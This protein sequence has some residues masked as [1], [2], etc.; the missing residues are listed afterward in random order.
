MMNRKRP[1]GNG[2]VRRGA[3]AL[4]LLAALILSGA[5]CA[6]ESGD[7]PQV[8]NASGNRNGPLAVD[9]IENDEGFSAILYDNRNGLPTSEA[10]AIAQTGD[11]F[12][13]IGSYAGLIRYDGNTFERIQ[14]EEGILN[15]RCLY[16]DSRDRLWI[17]TNDF[18]VFCMSKGMLKRVDREDQ[19]VSVSI[20]AIAEDPEGVIYVGSAAGVATVDSELNLSL[21]RDDRLL[22]ET[23]LDMRAGSDGLIYGATQSGDLFVMKDGKVV[24]FMLPGESRAGNIFAVLPDPLRPGTVY[25]AAENEQTHTARIYCGT[26]EDGF[27]SARVWDVSPLSQVERIESIDGEIWI[28][29]GNGIGKLDENG[30][31]QLHGIPMDK[32]VGHVMTDSDGNLWFTSTRQCVMKIVPNRFLDL[33]QHYGLSEEIVNATC[34]QGQRLF[35]GTDSG[36]IV[37]ENGKKLESVPLDRAVT[38]SG[39][40]LETDDL[41]AYLKGV[42]IRSIIRDSGD[43]LWIGTWSE[44]GLLCYDGSGLTAFT[45]ED[46]MISAQARMVCEMEDGTIVAGQPDG[47]SVIR[48]GRVTDRFGAADGLAVT[49]ILTV[50]EGFDHE[51]ILGSDGGGIYIIDPD[52]PGR[53]VKHI[54]VKDGLQ[55]EVILRIKRSRCRDVLWIATGN[56]LAFMTPDMQVTTVRHFPYS[57]NYDMYE[58]STGD[59]WVLSSNGIYVVSADEML[60]NGEIGSF[61]Y[62]IPSGL[63]YIATSNSYSELTDAGELYI[64]GVKGTIKVNI[65][66]TSAQTGGMRPALPFIDIDGR[67]IYP[68]ENG[69]FTVPHGVRKLTVYPYVF[70]YFL[71]DPEVSYRLE[72]FDTADTTVSRS[73][74]GPV[75]YTNLR[76]GEY[77]FV[78]RVDDPVGKDGIAVSFGIVKEKQITENAAATIILDVASIFFM[79]GILIYTSLY[80]KRGRVDDKLFFGMVLVNM[81]IAFTELTSFLMENNSGPLIREL[82]YTQNTVFY[83]CL[84]FFTYLF[85]L[86]LDQRSHRDA[87]RLRKTKLIYGIPLLLFTVLLLIN[88]RTGWVFSITQENMYRSGP[89]DQTVFIPILFYFA[90]AEIRACRINPRLVILGILLIATRAA[91]DLWCVAISSTA[92][93]YTLFLVCAHIHVINR[94]MMNMEMQ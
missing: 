30:F 13:W 5:P 50:A 67:R 64:S 26:P 71:A 70:N 40:D 2:H 16:V 24:F 63:P 86:Y 92:F 80:R 44:R 77:R 54:G 82:M 66:N 15:T 32:L 94:P 46:G 58:S 17:G 38:A 69:D 35:I 62:G 37:I 55:S 33:F 45:A 61:F 56:S 57:N 93:M 76:G 39:K 4:L 83:F 31:R 51:M 3:F 25:A 60:E 90:A 42:R 75:T 87:A 79:G 18:G 52:N 8:L 6:A 20:R 91:L 49:G 1:G 84:C 59:V 73:D 12:I 41:A 85:L 72:G 29:A 53:Q 10:N 48:D 65:E 21:S 19:L 28:C 9:P 22:G 34:I 47:V 43:R 74:L 14:S 78:L 88:L 23:V 11:G 68:D 7:A 89:I 27:A 36:L 81:T